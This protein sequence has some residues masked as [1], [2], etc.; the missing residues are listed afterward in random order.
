MDAEQ[1]VTF[2]GNPYSLD[3]RSLQT[4]KAI[5]SEYPYCHSAHMLYLRNLRNLGSISFHSQLKITAAYAGS[6]RLL[7][8]LVDQ[9][10]KKTSGAEAIRK[11]KP[12]VDDN[13]TFPV[14][15]PKASEAAANQQ[16]LIN[17]FITGQPSIPQARKGFYHPED[18]ARQSNADN[19]SIVSET[20]AVLYARQGHREKAINI[21][22]Q[23]SLLIPE[24]SRYFAARI[25]KLRNKQDIN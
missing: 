6:R 20:L 3:D 18:Y 19:Q 7:R 2:I 21:Y 1:F 5:I 14:I 16:A 4:L 13:I 24:K 22:E 25:E 23:L 10:Y 11:F 12:E 8:M 15:E 9:P 17:K